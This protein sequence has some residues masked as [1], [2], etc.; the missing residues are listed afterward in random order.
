M[1]GKHDIR[2]SQKR[3]CDG[4]KAFNWATDCKCELG[5]PIEYKYNRSLAMQVDHKPKQICPKPKTNDQLIVC[6]EDKYT[7]AFFK[8]D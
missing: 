7:Y 6:K 5:F 3:K 8:R 1:M 4:C 2:M